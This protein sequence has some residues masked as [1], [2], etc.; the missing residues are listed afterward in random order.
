MPLTTW[1]KFWIFFTLFFVLV[2]DGYWLRSAS[3]ALFNALSFPLQDLLIKSPDFLSYTLPVWIGELLR[4]IGFSLA[5]FSAFMFWGSK[6]NTISSVNRLIS[7]SLIFEG[8]YFLCLLPTNLVRIASG[9]SPFLLYFAFVLQGLL[10]SPFLTVLGFKVWRYSEKAEASVLRWLS[11]TG[12]V[13]LAGMWI[14]NVFRWFSMTESEG[15]GFVL[16]GITSLGFLNSIITLSASLIFA[17]AGVYFFLK[18][19]AHSTSTTLLALALTALSMHF[20]I[21]MIY[22]LIANAL[23]WA[24]LIE[25]WPIALLG[26]GVSMLLEQWRAHV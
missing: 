21:F 3:E 1:N 25:I 6:H 2:Y 9:R 16:H 8:I 23:K 4:F 20:V 19:D 18:K 7:V 17:I 5:L 13:Y 15:M 22:S 11:V 12:I 10:V 26:L 14:N 24:L